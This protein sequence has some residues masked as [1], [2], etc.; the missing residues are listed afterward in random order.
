MISVNE[1]LS[2]ITYLKKISIGWPNICILL[3]NDMVISPASS[4]IIVKMGIT[5]LETKVNSVLF[6][7]HDE[8]RTLLIFS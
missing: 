5:I 3:M 2:E 6:K 4:S 1:A 7:N 8:L